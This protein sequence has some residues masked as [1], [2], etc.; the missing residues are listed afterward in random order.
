MTN[1]MTE[2]QCPHCDS[3]LDANTGVNDTTF[4]TGDAARPGDWTVCF[5]CAN[6]L[7]FN[8]DMTLRT[9]SLEDWSDTDPGQTA[10]IRRLRQ[11]IGTLKERHEQ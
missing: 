10:F 4:D 6:V 1:R 3:K 7:M 5:S 2:V 11:A 9:P 8:D